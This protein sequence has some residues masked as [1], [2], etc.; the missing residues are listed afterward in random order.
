[1]SLHFSFRSGS[2]P[3]RGTTPFRIAILGDFGGRAARKEQH[4]RSDPR[5]IDCDNFEQEFERM[6]V[7]LD[8]PP[9]EAG[10][11]EIHLRF[12][13]LDGFHPDR[14]ID[15][16][17]PLARLVR[18][19]A[20]LLNPATA[21][22][23]EE[24][25]GELLKGGVP[26]P[27]PVSASP[28]ES[29][30]GMLA[31]LLGQTAAEQ[32]TTSSGQTVDRFIRQVI[33]SNAPGASARNA[34]LVARVET[35]LSERLRTLLHHPKFQALEAAWR[36]LDFLVRNAGEAV[37][38][39]VIDCSRAELAAAASGGDWTPAKDSIY[40]QLEKIRPGVMLGLY[41][42]GPQ[43]H[44][45]LAGIAR[46]ARACQ[47]AFVAGA[48]PRLVGCSSF[49]VQPDAD[50]WTTGSPDEAENF[51][52]LRRTPEAAHLGLAAPRFLLRQPYGESSDPI[53][54]FPF[55]EM[56]A[57]PEHEAYLWGN[58][59]LLCG[60]LLATAAADDAL[61][62]E[63]EEGGEVSG[64]PLHKFTSNGE[65][66]VKPSAEAWL[67][68]RAAGA[69]LSH[70]IMPVASIRGRDAVQLMTLQSV[71]NPPGPLAMRL[72]SDE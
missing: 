41:T 69:I 15:E 72:G 65:T 6:D 25:S 42:F 22:Q 24:E 3:K 16:F 13:E 59:A 71:S 51:E 43:D 31:R 35:E 10:G 48:S 18:L 56:A 28:A 9:G 29:T 7:T 34:E 33:G 32:Y 1:M 54:T 57:N 52:A 44:A 37:R 45:I 40:K 20:G 26:P 70:G 50:D 55:E 46:L 36:G 64:L 27:G 66:Q 53:E 38:L 23:A 61:D 5:P 62:S 21:N 2:N 63:F 39:Y 8:L 4:R 67:N 60:Y 12:R 47:S 68:E 14:L 19:R 30:E 49:G 58:P 11:Q 17:E